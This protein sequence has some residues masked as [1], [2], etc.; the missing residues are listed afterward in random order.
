MVKISRS[1]VAMSST[2]ERDL[3]HEREQHPARDAGTA[4]AGTGGEARRAETNHCADPIPAISAR[5][6]AQQSFD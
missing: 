3:R 6:V 2:R 5:G 1:S 4:R